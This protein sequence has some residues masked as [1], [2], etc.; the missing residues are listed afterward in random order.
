[1]NQTLITWFQKNHPHVTLVMASKYLK[2]SEFQTFI[3]AGINDFGENRVE[4]FL[5]KKALVHDVTWHFIGTLQSK[6]VKKVINDIDVLH[7]LDRESLVLEIEK[8][9]TD[10]LPCMIQCNI[11][12]EPNKHGVT[13][14]NIDTLLK[15]LKEASHIK[16]IGVMGMAED[17]DNA[18]II[19]AQFKTL[20]KYLDHVKTIFKDAEA[21]SMGMSQDYQI[22]LECGSTHVRLGRILLEETDAIT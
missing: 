9:R 19:A 10:V 20:N 1:M 4:S 14:A 12:N 22:A 15:T 18:D 5:E 11:S 13:F 21:L 7:T 16:I 2:A 3:D 6:K 8:Y 17:T